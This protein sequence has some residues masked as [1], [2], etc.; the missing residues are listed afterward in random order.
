MERGVGKESRA[1]LGVDKDG[2][3]GQI[4]VDKP[5][6][7]VEEFQGFADLQQ[8]LLDFELIDLELTPPPHAVGILGDIATRATTATRP[9]LAIFLL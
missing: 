1:D 5:R 9:F 4:C 6:I 8:A 2:I 3:R 7:L